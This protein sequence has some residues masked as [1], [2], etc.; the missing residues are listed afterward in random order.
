MSIDITMIERLIRNFSHEV[1]N[2]LTSIKG[3][4]QL[5]GIKQHDLDFVEKTRRVIIEN[6]EEIDSK[7]NRLYDLF[8]LPSCASA[9][10]NAD[11]VI[12][13]AISS[14]D[15]VIKGRVTYAPTSPL[16][17]RGN[18]EFLK[19]IVTIFVQGFDWTSNA[20]A[21]LSLRTAPGGGG[22][23]AAM[24]LTYEGADLSDLQENT[25]FLPF[26][27]RRFFLTGLELFEVYFL[28]SRGGWTISLVN[29]GNSKAFEIAF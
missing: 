27:E 11:D 25:C 15:P 13:S 2:P 3:Y 18:P 12:S 26:S 17:V 28:C 16:S 4:A 1:K 21:V 7:I 8:N 22:A 10:F 24:T 19:R 29:S 23:R 5:L 14:C 20:G 6:V 9:E